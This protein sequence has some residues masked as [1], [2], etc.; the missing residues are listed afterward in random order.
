MPKLL[1][2][3]S[4]CERCRKLVKEA[5]VTYNFEE[6]GISTTLELEHCPVQ[7][8]L[9]F[10]DCRRGVAVGDEIRFP[11]CAFFEPKQSG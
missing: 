5:P 8:Y 2:P 6:E 10:Q 4:P 9:K 11:W 1:L 7:D 3:S